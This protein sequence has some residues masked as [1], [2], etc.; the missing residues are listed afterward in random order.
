VDSDGTNERVRYFFTSSTL[1]KGVIEPT[2][3][4]LVYASSSE[5]V[6]TLV[7]NV[8]AASSTFRF[9]DDTYIGTGT[10]LASPVGVSIIRVVQVDVYADISPS[11]APQPTYFTNMVTIRNLRSN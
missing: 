11:T 1:A 7:S 5:T 8:L 2:G 6:R 4:P 9:F 10:G 3:N